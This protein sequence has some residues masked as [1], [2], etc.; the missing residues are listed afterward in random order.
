MRKHSSDSHF[1]NVPSANIQRSSFNR[2]CGTKTTFDSGYLVPVFIDEALPG[3]T[4]NLRM[5]S[6]ARLATPMRPFM[7]NLYMDSHFFAVPLRLLWDNFQKFMGEQVNPD[8]S[9]DYLVPTMTAPAGGYSSQSLSD[10][11]AIPT[12]VAGIEHSSLWH[13]AYNLIYNEWFR[14]ENIQDSVVVDKDDGP[15]SPDDYALLRR[16][17]RHD[18]FTSALPWPQKGPAVTLPMT[19]SAPVTYDGS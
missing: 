6:F 19:G 5:T 12:G 8:D 4:F 11:F 1:T 10:Y 9:T 14:D 18:Y 7:D 13:R 2:S 16:G 3:D 15:D 17:K